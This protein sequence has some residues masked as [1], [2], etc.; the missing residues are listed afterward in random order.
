MPDPRAV[1]EFESP[2]AMERTFED[3]ERGYRGHLVIDSFSCET[4]TGGVRIRPGLTLEELRGA[5][6]VMTWKHRFLGFPNGGAKAGIE[7]PEDLPREE[8]IRRLTWFADAAADLVDSGTYA[9]GPDM[10]TGGALVSEVLERRGLARKRKLNPAFKGS[11]FYTALSTVESAAAALAV[12][13]QT[14]RGKTVAVE[15][16]GSV[17]ACVVSEVAARGGRVVA[18]S[19][20][21]GGIYRADGLDVAAMLG[22][23][24]VLASDPR[25]TRLAREHVLTLDVDVLLPCGPGGTIDADVAERIRAPVVSP[26]ANCAF[27]LRAAEVL[28]RKNRLA[29]PCFVAN[30]GGVIGPALHSGGVPESLVER[31]I[32]GPY[33]RRVADLLERALRRNVTPL[34]LALTE[35]PSLP[36]GARPEAPATSARF[37]LRTARRIARSHF[38]PPPIAAI[39]TLAYFH[40]QMRSRSS[41]PDR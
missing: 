24:D 26:G 20:S 40:R 1:T 38:V 37:V 15:G 8:K 16:F 27:D 31:L 14:I 29:V 10:G 11:G 5:A 36:G 12:R 39:P 6:R 33:R 13:E 25:A 9:M 23:N 19:R 21:D 2:P 32:T 22:A 4:A 41:V 28:R 7:G 17:G 3:A 35:L 18:V 30:C 34:E